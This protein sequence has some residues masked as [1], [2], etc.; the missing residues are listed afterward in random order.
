MEVILVPGLWLD[1]SSWQDVGD[2]LAAAGHE[3]RA[4][5]LHGLSSRTADRTGMML[6]DHVAEIVSAIDRAAGPVMLVGH[7]EACGLVH[8]AVNR[9]P[10]RVARAVYVGGF[11]SADG[12]CVLTGC[13]PS[14]PRTGRPHRHTDPGLAALHD[15]AEENGTHAVDSLQRLTDPRRYDVPVTVIATEFRAD[16]VRRWRSADQDPARELR[17]IGDVTILDLPSGRWPQI[18]RSADLADAL[19]AALP[20]V[21]VPLA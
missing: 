1:A 6:A 12:T 2:R 3:P 4:L 11:P 8:A 20:A 10:D 21:T 9:R 17:R 5:T 14:P 15:R 18:E 16:D 7:A 19:L 13:A